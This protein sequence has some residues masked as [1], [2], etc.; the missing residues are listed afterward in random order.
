MVALEYQLFV[1]LREEVCAHVAQDPGRRGGGGPG[2]CAHLPFAVVAAANQYCMPLVDSSSVLSITEGRHPVVEKMLKNAVF[3]PN[4]THMDDGDDLCAI[5]TG[6]NM[7]GKSTYMR[8]VALIVPH[9][10]DGLLRPGPLRPHQGGGPG[11]HPH[12][13]QRRPGRRTVHPYGGDERGGPAAEKRQP[14]P[15]LILDEIGR[16][17]PPM[18]AWPSPGRCWSTA[19]TAAAWGPRPSLPPTTTSSPSWRGRSRG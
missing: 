3:V 2:G 12:R 5:I 6:P 10:P 19:P 13:G 4:D 1:E 18:T 15:L 7:A 11:V 14:P 9:G 8:Q 17:P 16:G